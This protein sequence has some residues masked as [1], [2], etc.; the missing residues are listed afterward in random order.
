VVKLQG[1]EMRPIIS[2]DEMDAIKNE[3]KIW[4]PVPRLIVNGSKNVYFKQFFFI[5]ENF[6]VNNLESD[7]VVLKDL[8]SENK[9]E[10]RKLH[11][12]LQVLA[13][14]LEPAPKIYNLIVN[15]I[16]IYYGEKVNS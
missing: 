15:D 5:L 10:F 6:F 3:K 16:C 13:S 11:I 8:S 14:W 4:H 7:M 9:Y 2:S 12:D 1:D